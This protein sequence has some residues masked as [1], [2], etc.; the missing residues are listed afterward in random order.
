MSELNRYK[1]LIRPN[2]SILVS[3]SL[4]GCGSSSAPAGSVSPPEETL[5]ITGES[6]VSAKNDASFTG[7]HYSGSGTCSNCHDGL[8]GN[9]QNISIVEKWS[10]SMMANA[11]RD[12][13]WQAKFSSELN[14]NSHLSEELNNTC[15]RCHAPMANDSVTKSGEKPE[16]F[17]E[18]YLN[19][20]NPYFD[21]AM[22]GVSCS[23][24]H[25]I[26]D[27]EKLGTLEGFSGQY[28]VVEQA[29]KIDR[30]AYG[31]Y[32]DPV[33][34]PMQNN[35]QFT[36]QAG[37]HIST[38]ELCAT[39]H[40]LKTPFVDGD[41]NIASSSPNTEFPEQ[42]V[43]TE[44]ENSDF[45]SGGPG[46]KSCQ[47]CHMPKVDGLTLISTKPGWLE[48]R[49]DFAQH[50]FLGANTV[51]MSILNANR[52]QLGVSAQGFEAAIEK[53]RAFLQT[54]ANMQLLSPVIENDQLSVQVKINNTAGHKLPSSYPSRRVW[55]YFVVKNNAGEILF[56]SGVLN[57]DGSIKDVDLDSDS[58]NFEPHYDVITQQ[59]QVQIYE[60]IME[61]TD[62]NVT[63]TLLRAAR[64]VKDNRIPPLG[65][66]KHSVPDDVRVA[67]AALNDKNFDNGSDTVTYKVN[68]GDESNLTITAELKYQAL[69]YG[70]LQDLFK[71]KNIRKV[72][73]F[74]E[75]FDTATIRAETIASVGIDVSRP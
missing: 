53:N 58:S 71:D 62:G 49:N 27:T 45:N 70:H 10:T 47:N 21:H 6:L 57:T 7:N 68:I 75:M 55:V 23:F 13:Y 5:P 59:D 20:E 9:A 16:V 43:Y 8:T 3:L 69:S 44:W 12:P 51:M 52:D 40:N 54:A 18:G 38:S 25:Q 56:E 46:E 4:I 17:G 32:V 50:D 2:L 37:A 30:P 34:G 1:L 74:K 72:A 66:N 11:T 33:V 63:H 67:G 24:C 64:Y 73:E 60:P 61:D 28:T 36:P 39:C 29:N 65:F 15:S 48:A 26:E 41:G 14:R 31:Q 42:M 19:P 35:V 22:D